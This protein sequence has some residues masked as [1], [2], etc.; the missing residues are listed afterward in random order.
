MEYVSSHKT[1]SGLLISNRNYSYVATEKERVSLRPGNDYQSV[2]LHL[3]QTGAPKMDAEK[4]ILTPGVATDTIL[5]TGTAALADTVVRG[6]AVWLALDPMGTV[7][8]RS[9][10]A[11]DGMSVEYGEEWLITWIAGRTG[12]TILRTST[13]PYEGEMETIVQRGQKKIGSVAIPHKYWE[14]YRRYTT[15]WF[16]P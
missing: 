8:E 5:I 14:L 7:R 2:D 10:E 3:R 11:N 16:R 4:N 9:L 12:A 15:Q 1:Q 6:S 13:P